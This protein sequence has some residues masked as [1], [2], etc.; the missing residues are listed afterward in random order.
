M[1]AKI[2]HYVS[3]YGLIPKD[4]MDRFI[5]MMENIKLSKKDIKHLQQRIM[6]I[7]AMQTES[8]AFVIYLEPQATPRPRATRSGIFYVQGAKDNSNLF[9]DFI[10]EKARDWDKISTATSMLVD[11]YH[12]IP[13]NMNRV[14]QILAELK[15]IHPMSKPD[16]DNLGKTYSD[17]IVDH[18]LL[19]D[20]ITPVGTVRRFYSFKPR[21]EVQLTFETSYDSNY[22]KKK[23][24]SWKSYDESYKEKP[25]IYDK[26]IN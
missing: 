5:W 11:V 10:K 4:Q 24:E 2:L 15:L 16:W 17:M 18:L 14:D 12:P 6:E 20:A 23:I 26:K 19:D 21:V 13:K 3:R 7:K 8:I 22:N 1:K 9:R 25:V